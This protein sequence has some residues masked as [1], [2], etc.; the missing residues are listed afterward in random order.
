MKFMKL[1]IRAFSLIELMIVVAIIGILVGTALPNFM[2]LVEDSKFS[3]ARHDLDIIK[4][5]CVMFYTNESRFPNK[6][7]ELLGKYMAKIPLSPWGNEYFIDEF[8][9]VTDT[10]SG[11]LKMP[12]YNPGMIAFIRD[13]DLYKRDFLSG[14]SLGLL[15]VPGEVKSFAWHPDG[16]RIYYNSGGKIYSIGINSAPEE[17]VEIFDKAENISISPDGVYMTYDWGDDLYLKTLNSHERPLSAFVRNARNSHWAGNSKGMTF[18]YEGRVSVVRINNGS[19]VGKI[20]QGMSGDFPKW[21]SVNT[22]ILFLRG[23]RLFITGAGKIKSQGASAEET[24][25]ADDVV[26]A[27][28]IPNSTKIVYT[29]S[30]GMVYQ[31]NT[32]VNSPK[33]QLLFMDGKNVQCCR[34]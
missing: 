23:R 16:S 32:E 18:V 13:G 3:K 10:P 8:Y 31:I 19:I 24:E 21:C 11:E 1:Y 2:N 29:S 5:Q 12:F 15:S 22:K 17:R 9:V 6:T 30:G 27:D 34:M 33:P 4:N 14:A 7:D 20:L 28:W 25:I 26:S